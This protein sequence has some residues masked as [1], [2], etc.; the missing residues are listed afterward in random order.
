MSSPADITLASGASNRA[1]SGGI[2]C[3]PAVDVY[4][5]GTTLP[6]VLLD[7]PGAG[8]QAGSR[9]VDRDCLL[10]GSTRVTLNVS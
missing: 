5:M 1:D 7:H 4:A 6:H 2:G 8:V 9:V 3:I 10:D